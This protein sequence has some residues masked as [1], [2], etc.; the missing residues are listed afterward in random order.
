MRGTN[1]ELKNRFE[2]RSQ[3]TFDDGWETIGE[4]L[5][6]VQTQ[7]LVDHSKS[8][9]FKNDSPDMPMGYSVNPYRGCEHGCAYCRARPYHEYLGFSAGIDFESKIMVK[10]DAPQLLRQAFEKRS[11][12][13]ECVMMSGNTDCYQPAE[14]KYRIT[15]QLLEVCLDYRNPVS[16][17]TKNALILRD[18]DLLRELSSR[19]LVRTMLSITSFDKELRRKL[20][21]RTS[22][23]EMK[24]KAISELSKAG[25]PVGVMIGPIIP[26]LNDNEIPS[27][28]KRSGEA[29]ATFVAHTILRLPHAVAPI[30]TDWLEKNYPEKANRVITRVKM[31]RGGKLNDPRWGTRMTGEG[32]YADYMHQ[33]VAAITKRYGMD[34]PRPPLRTDLFRRAGAPNLFDP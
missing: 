22:T 34:K 7:F 2:T 17:L 20:E 23:A 30:F 18:L 16:I 4:E 33:L 32:G 12:K 10:H 5:P 14:R 6:V 27:I 25:V 31:I 26:G 15:R 1:L 29:G 19:S 8:I 9:I 28:L 13:P 24:L 3:E 11:W 21:P